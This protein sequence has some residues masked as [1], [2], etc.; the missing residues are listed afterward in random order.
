MSTV[1]S[2]KPPEPPGQNA[3]LKSPEHATVNAPV[4]SIDK[5]GFCHQGC[6]PALENL[7]LTMREGEFLAIIGPN[8]GG[9][10]TLL[11]LILGLLQP[12]SGTLSV[13]GKT[14]Q[15]VSKNIGYVPQFSTLRT[16]FPAT[17]LETVLMGGASPSFFGGS[18]SKSREAKKRATAYLE[19]L[20][21]S[22]CV[23]K[24][25]SNLSGGQR[26][27]ALV[28]RALMSRPVKKDGT[29][30]PFL[31]LLDEPTAS[32]D[33]QGKFCFYEFL[34]NLRGSITMIVV[35]HDLFMVSPF[36]SS[37][38]FVNKTLTRF[39]GSR[40]SPENLTLLFGQH[41]HDCPVA[42]IQHSVGLHHASGCSHSAC[43]GSAENALGR[44]C[45]QTTVSTE[46]AF[47]K[48]GICTYEGHQKI[49]CAT[50][51]PTMSGTGACLN[52]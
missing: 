3:A 39:E 23:H 10:T 38:A 20:G 32:I 52:A 36:F 12:Q 44:T 4:V 25:V 13:F 5:L 11:R 8:G 50:K 7:S 31:L 16:D 9:K 34:G 40:L 27:R 19:V 35:S 48:A 26:Q 18:W 41:M 29:P 30:A 15:S 22:D 24:P 47:C 2:P 17:V 43:A 42:D 28:A 6:E 49:E 45:A 51:T 21:L 46:C 14:P 37:I 33:P 1:L